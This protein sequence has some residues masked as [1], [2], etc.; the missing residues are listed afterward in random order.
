MMLSGI[1]FCQWMCSVLRITFSQE[2]SVYELRRTYI[3]F[4]YTSFVRRTR[5]RCDAPSSSRVMSKLVDAMLR[6]PKKI[7]FPWSFTAH[8]R[9]T[10]FRSKNKFGICWRVPWHV[11][12]MHWT[13]SSSNGLHRRRRKSWTRSVIKYKRF[14]IVCLREHVQVPASNWIKTNI[15]FIKLYYVGW[16]CVCVCVSEDT[17]LDVCVSCCYVGVVHCSNI[18]HRS[19][20]VCKETNKCAKTHTHT[21]SQTFLLYL[22]TCS[23]DSTFD[24]FNFIVFLSLCLYILFQWRRCE[25]LFPFAVSS[26]L[27]A[28]HSHCTTRYMHCR[29]VF[30]VRRVNES[31]TQV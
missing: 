15:N 2:V 31:K 14:C 10:T 12:R 3:I 27:N 9:S 30:G 28:S 1:R 19:H 13:L 17:S 26:T 4:V 20:L 7:F 21:H 22:Q 6:E 24:A 29:R 8:S 5:M 11:R 23:V 16:G 25:I 18:V